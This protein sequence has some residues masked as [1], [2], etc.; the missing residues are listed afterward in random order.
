MF[1]SCIL[2]LLLVLGCVPHV[3]TWDLPWTLP[4]PLE[5]LEG[6]GKVTAPALNGTGPAPGKAALRTQSP[7]TSTAPAGRG[8]ARC[9]TER[10]TSDK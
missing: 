10:Q 1:L 7:V 8:K 6:V 2:I 9:C 5:P 4:V 3:G